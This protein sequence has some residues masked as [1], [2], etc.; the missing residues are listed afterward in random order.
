MKKLAFLVI[1]V[2]LVAFISGC[3]ATTSP[4]Q[5]LLGQAVS[6]LNQGNTAQYKELVKKAYADDPND[7]FVINNMG[8]VSEMDGNLPQ[9][10]AFYMEA[11]ARAGSLKIGTTSDS[12]YSGKPLKDMAEENLKRVSVRN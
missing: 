8:V 2:G 9:A 6:N 3:A 7:A 12:R 10:K 1:I 11:I 4:A 5:R